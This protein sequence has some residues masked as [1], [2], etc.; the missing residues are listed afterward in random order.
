ME[1]KKGKKTNK[2]KKK[3]TNKKEQMTLTNKNRRWTMFKKMEFKMK[4]SKYEE[5][6]N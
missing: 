1:L 5:I 6:K 4:K 2:S 3:M